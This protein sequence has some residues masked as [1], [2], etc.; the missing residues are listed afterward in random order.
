MVTTSQSGTTAINLTGNELA[1]TINGNNGANLI[2]GNGGNDTISGFSGNDILYGG[3]GNDTLTGGAGYD[4]FVFNTAISAATN[5]DRI[6]DFN[7]VQD[8]IR[9]DN[10]VMPGLGA[11]LGTCLLPRSGKARPAS[12]TTATTASSTRPTPAG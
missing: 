5:V 10:A 3:A 4:N 1:Q 6:T 7:V 8:T 9:L 11:S 12:P 2:R